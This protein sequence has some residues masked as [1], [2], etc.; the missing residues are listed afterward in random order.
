MGKVYAKSDIYINNVL[1]INAI[2]K[3]H[4]KRDHKKTLSK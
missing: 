3:M 4:I 2:Q 1:V